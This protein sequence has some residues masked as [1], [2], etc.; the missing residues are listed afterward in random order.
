M[1]FPS[2]SCHPRRV[3]VSEYDLTKEKLDKLEKLVAKGTF[4]HCSLNI[5]RALEAASS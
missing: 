4:L 3:S 5:S 1:L 2:L